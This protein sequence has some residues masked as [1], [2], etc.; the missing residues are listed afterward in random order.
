MWTNGFYRYE[1]VYTYKR[2]EFQN[3]L[4][5][6][7]SH[8]LGELYLFL[9]KNVERGIEHDFELTEFAYMRHS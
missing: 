3:I 9:K 2:Q 4:E 8:G 7:L 5:R 1:H 6:I